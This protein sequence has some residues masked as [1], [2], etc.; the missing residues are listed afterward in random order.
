MD[1]GVAV[2]AVVD[3]VHADPNINIAENF[4]LV[5]LVLPS[6]VQE[7]AMQELITVDVGEG[8]E[9]DC[10]FAVTAESGLDLGRVAPER[11]VNN[12]FS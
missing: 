11:R 3:D 2:S 6:V 1:D 7:H 5:V 10:S 8:Y 4:L 12:V 9:L